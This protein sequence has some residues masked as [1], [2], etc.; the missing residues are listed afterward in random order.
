M[1]INDYRIPVDSLSDKYFIEPLGDFHVGNINCDKDKIIERINYIKND[2]NR[3][4]I[5][6]GDLAD[7]ITVSDKR[8][9][10]RTYDPF[11]QEPDRQYEYV[12]NLLE[13]IKHKII[14]IHCGNHDETLRNKIAY[15]LRCQS[16][17]EDYILQESDWVQKICNHLNVAYLDLDAFTRLTFHK[18]GTKHKVVQFKIFSAHGVT[19]GSAGN[20]LSK[21]ERLTS[22]FRA[23]IYLTGHSHNIIHSKKE[24][25][26][27]GQRGKNVLEGTYVIASTGAFLKGYVKGNKSYVEKK[28]LEPKRTGTITIS[29][30]PDS[31]NINFHS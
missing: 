20:N 15:S 28:L 25:I 23:D 3:Y 18:T 21:L 1:Q 10:S 30:M 5:I 11:L 14:G 17:S 24:Y 6:M 12:M 9:D 29:I 26:G 13:P 22:S 2:T 19:S 7:C 4:T 27:V 16:M 31:R 8:W